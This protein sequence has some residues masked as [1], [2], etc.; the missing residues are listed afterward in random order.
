MKFQDYIKNETERNKSEL[1]KGFSLW[2][3]EIKIGTILSHYRENNGVNTIVFKKRMFGEKQLLKFTDDDNVIIENK[4]VIF[5]KNF[6]RGKQRKGMSASALTMAEKRYWT[7][8]V[9]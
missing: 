6:N 1:L 2:K 8:K 3:G 9:M 5:K 4:K 7:R